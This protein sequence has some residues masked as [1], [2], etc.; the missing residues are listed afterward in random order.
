MILLLR[1]IVEI[2]CAP[3][4]TYVNISCLFEYIDEYMGL[5][6][7]IF[8]HIRLRPKHHYMMHFPW[9]LLQFG[10]LIHMWTLRFESKHSYFKD[11]IRSPGNFMNVSYTLAKTHQMLQS[12]SHKTELFQPHLAPV[13]DTAANY[14]ETVMQTLLHHNIPI[15]EY[16]FCK[17][18]VYKGTLYK[19][20]QFVVTNK[21][22]FDLK[23]GKI[24]AVFIFHGKLWFVVENCIGKFMLHLGIYY[25]VYELFTHVNFTNICLCVDDLIS[26]YPL[27]SYTGMNVG[28]NEI[29]VLKHNV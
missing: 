2:L 22:S 20:K 14:S 16:T 8:S 28:V 4:I 3:Q 13:V 29:L 6:S 24:I 21:M 25:V 27:Y 18:A 5:R 26:F 15:N 19:A 9:L 1:L 17:E 23:L 12:Y 11:I 7:T 10:P